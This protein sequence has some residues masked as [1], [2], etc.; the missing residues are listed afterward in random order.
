MSDRAAFEATIK[1]FPEDDAPKL[2]YADWLEER[3][4]YQEAADWR[5]A[6][7]RKEEKV[8]FNSLVGRV[9]KN[10]VVTRNVPK[11]EDSI[12]FETVGG[13]VFTLYHE[14]DCCEWVRINDIN[15]DVKDLIGYPITMATEASN[16]DPQEG[17]EVNDYDSFTW[18][19]YKLA[20][21][22]GYVDIRW[23]GSSNGYYSESVDFKKNNKESWE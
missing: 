12:R 6:C 13:D 19:F 10:V 16:S 15:G 3:E 11:E 8:T 20:T 5:L 4:Y 17:Q 2:V 1:A 7:D 14:Q 22:K 9:L 21:V 23:F 18:T